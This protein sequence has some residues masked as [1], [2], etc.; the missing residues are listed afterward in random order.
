MSEFDFALRVSSYLGSYLPGQRNLSANTIASYRDMFKLLIAYFGERGKKPERLTMG[1][2]CKE[3]IE[4]FMAWLAARGCADTTINQRLCAVK[5]FVNYV[6]TEDPARMLQYQRVLAIRQRKATSARMVLPG[7]DGLAAIL[8]NP[9]PA[10]PKGR[11]D[12][13]LLT[14][15]YDSAARVSELCG[16]TL[17]AVRLDAPSTLSLTGKGGKTRVVPLM[18]GTAELLFNHIEEV[19]AGFGPA[20][21][22]RPLFPNPRGEHLTRAGVADVVA[23]H[24]RGARESGA[25]VPEGVSPHSFRH[26]KAVDLVGAGVELIYIRDFLGHKSVKTTEIYATICLAMQREMLE[27]VAVTTPREYPDWSA[28]RDL[29]AWLQGLC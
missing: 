3:E 8:A 24:A 16:I 2:V 7:Q 29:M 23:R 12:R 20:E 21:L 18:S 6:K 4:G 25:D 27:R 22:D 19:H 26:Q 11:R 9:D 15:L 13:A 28:D 5:A 1:D 10:M 17:R 14:L